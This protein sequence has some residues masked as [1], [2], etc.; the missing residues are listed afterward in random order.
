MLQALENPPQNADPFFWADFS[1]LRALIHPDKCYSRG[2]LASLSQRAKDTSNRHINVEKQWHDMVSFVGTRAHTFGKDYPFQVTD[3]N[4]TLEL[5]YD[6]SPNQRNYLQLLLASLMRHIPPAHRSELARQFEMTCFTVF[7]HLMPQGSEIRATWA[8]GGAEAP[9]TGT[10]FNKMQ[11]VAKDIRCT[12]NFQERD[13]KPSDSGDGG[14]DLI[15]WHPM[16]DH[17]AGIPIAFAQCGCS[18]EDWRYKHIEASPAKHLSNLP[19]KHPWATYYFLPIDLRDSDGGWANESDLGQ[20]IIVDRLRIMRL[21]AQ[22]NLHEEIPELALLET[23]KA[24]SYI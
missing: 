7:K 20:A 4:D 15:A 23:I 24:E 19:V 22:Y 6:E 2:D 13:F 8:N 17:R 14:I 5:K 12:A 11:Q 9:Y 21:V 16:A 3:D 10:L 18:K 1:E